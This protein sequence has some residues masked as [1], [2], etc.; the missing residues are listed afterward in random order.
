MPVNF[1]RVPPR[2]FVPAPPRPSV[3]FWSAL[4]I[5]VLGAAIALTIVLWP[6]DKPTNVPLF[7]LCCLVYPCALWSF[8]FALSLGYGHMRRDTARADNLARDKI[9]AQCHEEASRPLSVLGHAWRFAGDRDANDLEGVVS[10]T[11][12]LSVRPSG[13]DPD[14]DVHA[15]WLEIPGKPFYP[16]N[17]LGE[18]QRH[19]VVSEWLLAELMGEIAPGLEALPAGCALQVHL[20]L[21][22]LLDPQDV[23]A[24]LKKLL[25][26]KAPALRVTA[27]SSA[28]DLPLSEVD[29][30]HDDM[31]T[32][33]AQLLIAIHLRRAISRRLVDGEAEAGVALL[34]G[35][36]GVACPSVPPPALN[37]H[38]PATSAAAK[39]LNLATHW[40]KAEAAQIGAIWCH[41]PSEELVQ[42]VKSLPDYQQAQ[43]IDIG[44]SVGNCAGAGAWLATVLAIAHTFRTSSPQLVL[45]QHGHNMIALVC[46]K[47]I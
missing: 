34:L 43:W 18:H 20:S 32:N 36:P 23:G 27:T 12:R 9:E 35:P 39:A 11:T 45:S 8:F 44:E 10:G 7:W 5:V 3:L 33:D 16:G 31:R 13:A 28:D 17:V 41:L 1:H 14:S 21:Q 30:W 2:V 26:T 4:L 37:L 19:R 29:K 6:P 25:L 24:D 22:S 42:E 40:A 47:Q 46:K 15:R 38:R